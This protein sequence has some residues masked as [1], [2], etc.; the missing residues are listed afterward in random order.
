MLEPCPRSHERT[1]A[2]ACVLLAAV[3]ACGTR[4][5][6]NS[7]GTGSGSGVSSGSTSGDAGGSGA[8][9]SSGSATGTISGGG[10][11]SGAGT[12]SVESGS[13][14]ES[15]P[16]PTRYIDEAGT[17]S[18]AG[19]A[20]SAD[21]GVC[22]CVSDT[23]TLCT[24]DAG[25]APQCA[26]TTLDP[27]NCG[28]CGITC[29]TGAACNASTCG[30]EPTQLVPPA[31]GCI[32]MRLVYDNGN[33]YWSDLGH[34]TINRV[35]TTDGSVAT[36]ISGINIAAV[37]VT[38]GPPPI[39]GPLL[40]PNGP[41]ATAFV[42]HGGAVYWIGS[43]DNVTMDDADVAHGGVGVTIMSATAVVPPKTLLSMDLAPGPS[44]VS[45]TDAGFPLEIPGMNPPINAIALS[46]GGETIYFAAGT[47]F[48]SIPSGG[49]ASQADVRYLGYT[50]GPEHGVATALATDSTNLYY[51]AYGGTV[52][53][54]NLSLMCDPDAAAS[55]QCP[56]ARAEGQFALV[57]DQILVNGDFLYWGNN[58]LVSAG[59][60]ASPS[61]GTGF[62][63]TVYGQPIAGFAVG[64][65]YAY[66]GEQMRTVGY[67]E[68]G[69]PWPSDGGP[70][71]SARLLAIDQ[72]W[73]TSIVLDGTNV[74][75][76]TSRCN[77]VKV[78]D[79]PQ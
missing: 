34:G 48:Y 31:P 58:D 72:P 77:I 10:S 79:S 67:V 43:A 40:W 70:V 4:Q 32:S 68:K 53:I 78:A 30:Q 27:N 7:S 63:S 6:G 56:E 26:D 14:A 3:V 55:Q 29:K 52:E 20:Y 69:F 35:S 23:Q 51:L 16:G 76:A 49:A 1:S 22:S 45:A 73:P 64:A 33:I 2:L 59:N 47:R 75:W 13:G 44:P 46:P 57:Y 54:L 18:C 25:Q 9:S 39:L 60:I 66:F 62:S 17:C 71:P 5:S 37:Q 21:G 50:L 74:Y 19:N 15:C 42:E 28:G 65:Q 8:G 41:L 38:A 11:T 12:G 24:Y 36:I 61:N